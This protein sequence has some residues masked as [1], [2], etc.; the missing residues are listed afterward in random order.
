MLKVLYSNRSA[1][2]LKLKQNFAALV[3][4]KKCVELDS[5]WAKGFTRLGDANFSCGNFADSYNAYNSALRIDKN[6]KNLAEK[7]EKAMNAIAGTSSTTE[8]TWRSG[9]GSQQTT[10]TSTETGIVGKIQL[11]GRYFVLGAG[12]LY[13]LPLGRSFTTACFTSSIVASIA[14]NM[15]SLYCKCGFPKISI[16][17][18]QKIIPDPLMMNMVMAVLTVSNRPYILAFGSLIIVQLDYFVPAIFVV[19]SIASESV[20]MVFFTFVRL[21]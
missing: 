12:F 20:Q 7:L 6:D 5:N 11:F 17:Y 13:F 9:M 2:H 1:A 14:L 19:R 8:S 3:D 15:L 18:V 10:Q 4:A 16:D 21:T